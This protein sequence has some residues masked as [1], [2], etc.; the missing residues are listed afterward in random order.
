MATV[1]VG[2]YRVAGSEDTAM[3]YDGRW[4][5]NYE[6]GRASGDRVGGWSFCWTRGMATELSL[7]L[8]LRWGERGIVIWRQTKGGLVGGQRGAP[9]RG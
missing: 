1:S 9:R 6:A 2:R 8:C 7:E 4:A 3:V 5:P